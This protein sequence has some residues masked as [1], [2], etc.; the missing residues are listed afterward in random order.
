MEKMFLF[1]AL[2]GAVGGALV[3]ANSYKARALVKK[4]QEDLLARRTGKTGKRQEVLTGAA[5][6]RRFLRLREMPPARR[7]T[8]PSEYDIIVA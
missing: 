2:L 3:V 8:F 5:R 7:F 4:S 6:E 1:G